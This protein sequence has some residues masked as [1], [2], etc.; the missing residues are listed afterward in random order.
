M[1][2]SEKRGK[3]KDMKK[4]MKTDGKKHDAPSA[5]SRS[6]GI[7]AAASLAAVSAALQLVHVG[8]LSPWGMW[9]DF[10]AIPWIIAFLLYGF[11]T[12]LVVSVITALVITFADPSTWLGAGVKWIATVPMLI[13]MWVFQKS[14]R[15]EL[16][17]FRKVRYIILPLIVAIVLRGLIVIPVNYYFALPIWVG[18][19]PEQ[20]MAFVPWW[21]IFGMNAAQGII[22]VL[23][24]LLL[25]FRFRLDR[26][27]TWR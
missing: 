26:F 12:S 7:A 9:I 17:D 19:T 24:A 6:Y 27:S 15:L 23:L 16:K 10:V 21:I 22:E 18:W 20:A 8:W 4:E 25:V 1:K 3:E 11:R 2:K 14:L 5:S 13:C